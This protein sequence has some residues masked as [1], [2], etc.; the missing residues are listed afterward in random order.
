MAILIFII[1]LIIG[2]FLNVCIYRIP[3]EESIVFPPSHCPNCK[4]NLKL[5]DLIP[6]ISYAVLRGR[7]RYCKARISPV[8]PFIEFL[9]AILYF[10][11]YIKYGLN[12]EFIKFAFLASLVIVIGVIDYFTT[13]IYTNTII[14]GLIVGI[15]F[16]IISFFVE[17][18][19]MIYIIGSLIG[20]GVIS[21]IILLTNGMGWG[22]AE[23]LFII[24]LFLGVRLTLVTLFLSFIIG[25]IVG[26]IL[27]ILKIKSRKDYIPFGPFISIGAVISILFGEFIIN[28]LLF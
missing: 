24:G 26:G 18:S 20:G 1:G 9:N 21:L 6:L 19:I 27:I 5:K 17:G 16:A 11:I 3:R 15:A 25:G 13:D 23:L 7:C 14:V 10:L 12:L 28:K 2:S 22:D 8:Y 4:L